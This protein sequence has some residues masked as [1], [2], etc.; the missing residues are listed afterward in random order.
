MGPLQPS[1]G[2]R[3][4]V[5]LLPFDMVG[6]DFI[7]PIT[8][9]SDTGNHYIIIMVD[10]F[11]RN[12]FAKAVTQATGVA[13]KGLFESVT[14][15]FGN[16]LSVY[17]DN[18]AHFTGDDFY[19]LLVGRGIKHFPA[20][21]SHPSSVGL[22]KQYL[23]LLMGILKRRVQ[24]TGKTLWDTLI[25]STVQTLNTRGVKVHGFTPSELLLGYNP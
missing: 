17:T 10:Y 3:A 11:T 25:H 22:A 13:A 20:P 19:G 14:A 1:V 18:G 12:L 9:I 15:L 23:Q 6:L 2:S 16:P 21:K 7:G 5:D 24:N 4:I 8:P